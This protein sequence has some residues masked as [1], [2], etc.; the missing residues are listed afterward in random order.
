MYE[1]VQTVWQEFKNIWADDEQLVSS[2]FKTWEKLY[3]I[4]GK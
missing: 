4:S 3:C 2:T 1:T